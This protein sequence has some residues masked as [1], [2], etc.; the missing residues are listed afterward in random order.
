MVWLERA[1]FDVLSALGRCDCI[2]E[3]AAAAERLV[4]SHVGCC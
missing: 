3:E 1:W 2:E 4:L